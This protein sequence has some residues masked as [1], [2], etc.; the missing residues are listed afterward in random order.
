MA[1]PP[2]AR[3]RAVR[4]FF[5][6]ACVAS[7]VGTLMA[8]IAPFGQPASHAAREMIRTVSRIH[9]LAPGWGENT[10]ALP[11]FKAIIAL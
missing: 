7:I 9:F 3:I 8:D 11:P 6:S 10:M 2:V 4:S 1:P 5:I